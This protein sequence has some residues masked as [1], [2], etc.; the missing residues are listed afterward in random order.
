MEE[1]AAL[2]KVTMHI[3]RGCLVVLIQV[4]LYDKVLLQIQGDI[5]ERVKETGVK[6]VII[7]VSGVDVI[8]SFIAQ[9]I[10]DTA[11]MASMLGATTV[12]TGLKPGVV[13]SLIDLDF[14][15]KG[16]QTAITLEEGFRILEPVV[17]PREESKE[18][19]EPEEESG[20]DQEGGSYEDLEIEEEDD[21]ND[22][23]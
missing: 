2:S 17:L 12:L 15:P 18:I 20:E 16:I 22:E 11:R 6:G 8:D 14:E 9:T 23:E 19:E 7:D 4:E 13:A 1:K 3:T 21:E 5:L 10:S